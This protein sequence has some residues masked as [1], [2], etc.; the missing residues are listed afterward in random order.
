MISEGL[1]RIL[2]RRGHK[3]VAIFVAVLGLR[4]SIEEHLTQLIEALYG[5]RVEPEKNSV[6]SWLQK[7]G[8]QR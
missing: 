8:S 7:Q 3:E 2:A 1:F 5:D 6:N 4:K